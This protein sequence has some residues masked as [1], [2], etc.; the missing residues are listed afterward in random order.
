MRLQH[1]LKSALWIL[2][3][4]RRVS[5]VPPRRVLEEAVG[6]DGLEDVVAR[7]GSVGVDRL[8]GEGEGRIDFGGACVLGDP[9]AG[10]VRDLDLDIA[11]GCGVSA[12]GEESCGEDQGGLVSGW[13][14]ALARQ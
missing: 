14:F 10:A 1:R 3:D 12:T 9:H 13:H 5:T 11:W 8:F 2:G 6:V 4:S 7:V